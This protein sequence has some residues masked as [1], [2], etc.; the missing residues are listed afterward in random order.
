MVLMVVH[1]GGSSLARSFDGFMARVQERPVVA[2]TIARYCLDAI[3]R[4]WRRRT[5][6]RTAV[7]CVGYPVW[8]AVQPEKR[9]LNA[10]EGQKLDPRCFFT[11]RE[12]SHWINKA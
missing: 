12:D 4:I 8:V 2:T 7:S 11:G 6:C 3:A 1:P 10:Q 5:V 9:V